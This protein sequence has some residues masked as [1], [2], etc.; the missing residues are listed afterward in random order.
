MGTRPSWVMNCHRTRRNCSNPCRRRSSKLSPRSP[1]QLLPSTLLALFSYSLIFVTTDTGGGLGTGE[2]RR[3]KKGNESEEETCN[4]EQSET[5]DIHTGGGHPNSL[6]F[7]FPSALLALWSYSLNSCHHT[8]QHDSGGG[9]GTGEG[10]RAKKGKETKESRYETGEIHTGGGTPTLS[11]FAF[12][13]LLPATVLAL[14][15]YSLIFITTQND[16]ELEKEREREENKAS[17]VRKK[18]KKKKNKQE[19]DKPT[20]E[21]T[22]K[23]VQWE[24]QEQDKVAPRAPSPAKKGE[25]ETDEA[26]RGEGEGGAER[27]G[28]VASGE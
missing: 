23:Q 16:M 22:K 18:T 12:P 24:E 14:F 17:N 19:E 3:T 20:P 28:G 6:H 7:P 1:L 9:L 10:R 13:P 4:E 11:T 15:S 21:M 25:Q 5:G 2:G 26:A 27:E 8:G